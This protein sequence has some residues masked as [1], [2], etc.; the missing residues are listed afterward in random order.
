MIVLYP[1][2][3]TTTLL[4]CVNPYADRAPVDSL[5]HKAVALAAHNQH[6]MPT[7]WQETETVYN[8]EGAIEE[9]TLYHVRLTPTDTGE[10]D[11]QLI[12]ATYN[13]ADILQ[14]TQAEFA[15]QRAAYLQENP[16]DDPFNPALQHT[17]EVTATDQVRQIAGRDHVAM[18]YTQK[19]AKGT[20]SGTAWLDAVTGRPAEVEMQPNALPRHV[21]DLTIEGL[22]TTIRYRVDDPTAWY[23]IHVSV[24]TAFTLTYAFFFSFTG[25]STTEIVLS[26]YVSATPHP[27]GGR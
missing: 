18:R 21:D 15:S 4:A 26:A 8:A 19:T 25:T 3:I 1:L 23:P 9:T 22:K 11:L 10:P 13:G 2:L 16:E 20:W 5:W 7:H 17:L 24:E 12:K 14:A 27:S 6:W